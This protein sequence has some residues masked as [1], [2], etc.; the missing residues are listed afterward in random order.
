MSLISLFF[1]T[2]VSLADTFKN[3]MN[4]QKDQ[5]DQETK[6]CCRR[7]GRKHTALFTELSDQSLRVEPPSAPGTQALTHTS[8]NHGEC[9]T[10]SQRLLNICF[11]VAT[12]GGRADRPLSKWEELQ[13]PYVQEIQHRVF[14]IS[15]KPSTFTARHI[16]TENPQ[17]IYSNNCPLFQR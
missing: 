16:C 9:G 1:L 3:R 2:P 10:A 17:N 12:E 14:A 8:L 11:H 7:S 13:S 5:W 4:L 15:W 6:Q